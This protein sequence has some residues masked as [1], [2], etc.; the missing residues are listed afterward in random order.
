MLRGLFTFG[1]RTTAHFFCPV[2]PS[3]ILLWPC[4]Q[5]F[6]HE[7]LSHSLIKWKRHCGRGDFKIKVGKDQLNI[8][9]QFGQ[10]IVLK[11]TAHI[12][13][14]LLQG[15]SMLALCISLNLFI[16]K[17]IRAHMEAAAAVHLG[18]VGNSRWKGVPVLILH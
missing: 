17:I 5:I 3:L 1:C 11:N 4:F 7:Q 2:A 8:V 6:S 15:Q 10:L 12:R 14:K 18:K 16:H 13:D 9:T